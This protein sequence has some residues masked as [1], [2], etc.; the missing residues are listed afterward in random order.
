M[1][2][3]KIRLIFISAHLQRNI[4]KALASKMS[5]YCEKQRKEEVSNILSY[6]IKLHT[7][8]RKYFIDEPP[9]T[10]DLVNRFVE[11]I[12]STLKVI[13]ETCAA[14]LST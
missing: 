9:G 6:C 3:Y 5:K 10:G 11:E 4:L 1:F 13:T 2:Q 7:Q 14:C 12:D 8:A